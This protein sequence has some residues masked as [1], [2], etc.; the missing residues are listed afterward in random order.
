MSRKLT[1]LLFA[2]CFTLAVVSSVYAEDAVIR[3]V[4]YSPDQV[5]ELELTTQASSGISAIGLGQP[6]YIQSDHEGTYSWSI[7]GPA[8]SV[9][10]LSG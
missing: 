9:A 8:G 5:H 7:V 1:Y 6:I 3:L 10:V 4:G 2:A